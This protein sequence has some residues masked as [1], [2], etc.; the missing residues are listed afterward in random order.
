MEIPVK[1]LP[2]TLTVIV[3]RP[4]V[5]KT[6]IL[7]NIARMFQ[8]ETIQFIDTEGIPE[9]YFPRNAVA[10]TKFEF[11]SYPV[12]V[13]IDNIEIIVQRYRLESIKEDAIDNNRIIVATMGILP[14]TRLS[15]NFIPFLN[16]SQ[17]A[18]IDNLLHIQDGEL[19]IIKSRYPS[20]N[21]NSNKLR[22]F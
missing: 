11:S 20:D 13:L 8:D 10:C 7:T 14:Q 18:S 21:S 22:Q 4:G 6:I 9:E 16:E 2:K 5:G 3:G 17:L 12:V 19:H 15:D 1:L